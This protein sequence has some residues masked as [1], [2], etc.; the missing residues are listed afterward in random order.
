MFKKLDKKDLNRVLEILN[1][2]SVRGYNGLFASEGEVPWIEHF[3][4]DNRCFAFGYY[5]NEVLVSIILSEILS[6]N[7]CILWYIAT[8]P[9]KQNSGFGSNLLE[10]F[11]LYIKD[12]GIEWIFLNSSENSLEFYKKRGYITSKYSKVYEHVK[13]VI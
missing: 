4:V 3:I 11:E 13:D 9:N 10:E 5:D 8:D 2:D 1:Q 6:F 7:G 12:L